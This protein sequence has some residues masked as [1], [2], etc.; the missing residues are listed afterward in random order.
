MPP[1]SFRF[2]SIFVSDVHLGSAGCMVEEFTQFLAA[3]EC[4]HLYLVGDI[5]DFWVSMKGG[6]WQQSHTDVLQAILTKTRQGTKVFFTPGNHDAVL[7]RLNN[8]Q[9][10]NLSIGHSFEHTTADG[11]KLQVVHGDL[12]DNSVRFVPI[13]WMAAWGYEFLTVFNNRFNERRLVKGKKEVEFSSVFKKRLKRFIGRRTDFVEIL[14]DQAVSAGFSGVVCGHIHKPQILDQGAD[15]LYVNTGDWVEHGTA[16]V[17][18]MDGK[19]EL[20]TWRQIQGSV[21]LELHLPHAPSDPPSLGT[22]VPCVHW[23]TSS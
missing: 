8:S 7:R 22:A 17:E 5:I 15:G 3:V 1:H 2:R 19:L 20:L 14:T 21:Q 11:R 4:G 9:F 10:G 16:V 12:F 13:A 23:S 18:Y 6:K